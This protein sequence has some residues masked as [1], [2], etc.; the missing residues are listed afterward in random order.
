MCLL[1]QKNSLTWFRSRKVFSFIVQGMTEDS[2]ESG[3]YFKLSYPAQL[4]PLLM[5]LAFRLPRD[6]FQMYLSARVSFSSPL[7]FPISGDHN[8]LPSF[9]SKDSHVYTIHR[10][11][12]FF[13]VSL[14]PWHF[15]CHLATNPPFDA[16]LIILHGKYN[17]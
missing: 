4:T 17:F 6:H 9:Y 2:L 1:N 15:Y 14:L 7:Y 12:K 16:K 5:T 13:R 11:L 8:Q 10:L 3:F